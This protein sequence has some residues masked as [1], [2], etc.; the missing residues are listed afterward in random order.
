MSEKI[1]L[2]YT[3][4]TAVP[5]LGTVMGHHIVVNYIDSNGEHHMLLPSCA[6]AMVA[7]I[8]HTRAKV[9]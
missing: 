6:K 2:T 4:A 7:L 5:R 9:V 8:R 3:N 1:F